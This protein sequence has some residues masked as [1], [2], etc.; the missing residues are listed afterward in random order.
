MSIDFLF[1]TSVYLPLD[2][3][4]SGP[5][6]GSASRHKQWLAVTA[7]CNIIM[8]MRS[9]SFL[10]KSLVSLYFSPD[11]TMASLGPQVWKPQVILAFFLL[12]LVLCW[13]W[14]WEALATDFL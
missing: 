12:L 7:S 13:C 3:L 4:D 1:I 14:L 8:I 6:E 5:D 10:M 11:T 2:V 9:V